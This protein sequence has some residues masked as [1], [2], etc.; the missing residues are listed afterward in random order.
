MSTHAEAD[1]ALQPAR[2]IMGDLPAELPARTFQ[3]IPGI[4]CTP[5]G[6]LWATWYGGGGGEGKD[7][8]VML[9]S[10]PAGGRWSEPWLFI[11]PQHPEVR[12]YDP[13]L[14]LD[15][16]RRLWLFWA[17]SHS[18]PEFEQMP[19][20][21]APGSPDVRKTWDGRSGVWGLCCPQPDAQPRRWDPPV[22]FCDGIMM[23]KPTLDAR[24][25]WLMPVSIWDFQ[26]FCASVPHRGPTVAISA[27]HGRS[28]QM[29]AFADLPDR[30][31]DEHHVIPLRDGRWVMWARSMNASMVAT[32]SQSR[33]EGR[34]WTP[35]KHCNIPCPN[36]RFFVGRLHSGALLLVSH[37]ITDEV[38][39]TD[40]PLRP[41]RSHLA[42]WI[43]DD[44][45]QTWQGD[46]LIDE[47]AGVSY[48]DAAQA[49]DGTIHVIY[50]YQRHR[51]RHIL[52]VS[53]TEQQVRAGVPA[54]AIELVNQPA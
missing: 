45:G 23:N 31:F 30:I 25:R 32:M 40:R 14:W 37:R 2:V 29:Q 38:R 5:A 21:P 16:Q 36:S 15:P 19:R 52:M 24:G 44:E 35:G 1:P 20:D 22:R 48:P 4:A 10:R 33:D 7:N 39:A 6:T 26:P 28:A 27:D 9:A 41:V 47:R 3:G 53:I 50:D 11:D 8:Y 51:E 12:A 13:T 17:Q 18:K 46:L 54:P 43:S 49:D 34:T 42:A